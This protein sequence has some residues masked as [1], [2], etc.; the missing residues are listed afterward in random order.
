[1]HY[2]GSASGS[3]IFN[4]VGG[5][6]ILRA[7][8]DGLYWFRQPWQT[9]GAVGR[10]RTIVEPRGPVSEFIEKYVPAGYTFGELHDSFVDVATGVGIPDKVAN[11]PSMM[12]MYVN[13]VVIE[14]MRTIGILDQP[15]PPV[16]QSRIP[17]RPTQCK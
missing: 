4:Y 1:M 6:P 15:T 14:V 13:S 2:D 9:P 8:P 5:N 11:K 17:A 12:A 7:D 10:E 16:L 3:T